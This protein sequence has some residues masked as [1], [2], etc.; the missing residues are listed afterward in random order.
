MTNRC[1]NCKYFKLSKGNGYTWCSHKEHEGFMV[2][3]FT[4]CPEHEFKDDLQPCPFCG[5]VVHIV[6]CDHEGN[7]HSK[8][9]EQ[10]PWSGIGYML[11]HDTRDDVTGKC[12][13]AGHECEGVLGT[14]IYDTR[15]EAEYAWNRRYTNV[16][17][18]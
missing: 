4:S 1:D 9:Y 10:D 3:D 13:I 7:L 2:S 11:Y 8:E 6:I 15:E 14:F 18:N 5:G 17:N 12:P 16:S